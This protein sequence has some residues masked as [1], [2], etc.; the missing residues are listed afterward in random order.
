MRPGRKWACDGAPEG[1][2][3][4][5]HAK[6]WC[7]CAAAGLIVVVG[8]LQPETAE[9][10]TAK[11]LPAGIWNIQGRGYFYKSID[12][13]FDS[14]G[15]EE[16]LAIDLNGELNSTVFPALSALDAFVPGGS[17]SIG[18]S[19]VDYELDYTIWR[20]DLRYGITDKLSVEL[21]VPYWEAK[22]TVNA[23]VDSSSANVGKNP[24]YN[25]PAAGPLA[26]APLVPLG[27]GIGETALSDADVQS[28][29]GAGLDVNGDGTTDIDGFGYQPLQ[30]WSGSG[31]GDIQ[32][33][34]K[35][36]FY[37]EG[38]W[39][40]AAAAGVRLP[41][42]REDD[43]NNLADVPFGTGSVAALMRFY[44][45]YRVGKH[46]TFNATAFADLFFEHDEVKRVPA[47][48]N[49]P[50]TVQQTELQI[51]PGSIFEVD[52]Q[53]TYQAD[54]GVY[55]YLAYRG[56][57][58]EKNSVK[59]KAGF[60]VSSLED[61]TDITSHIGKVGIGFSSIGLYAQKKFPVPMYAELEYR[62]R[63]AG[64]NVFKSEFISVTLGVL[65]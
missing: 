16:P 55:G 17:A 32:I 4:V 38:P 54:S 27:T 30:T 57:V 56:G 46:W 2:R 60:D 42:G 22:N 51:T 13:R 31:F 43:P 49:Q 52:L 39:R 37:D 10:E 45:D 47:D 65:F 18:E 29:L 61:E 34:G 26:G 44:A 40:L 62:N 6:Q 48:V 41:T 3:A 24:L 11:V 33:G 59:G 21:R 58:K 8:A 12:E 25:N 53:A 50:L 1:G 36:K 28:L 35:Y 14:R 64:E 7:G 19:V 9:A 20:L 63:F 23:T 15:D 5:S